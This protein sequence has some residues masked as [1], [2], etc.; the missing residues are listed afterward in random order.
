MSK[1]IGIHSR[2]EMVDFLRKIFDESE[3]PDL[4]DTILSQP[5]GQ[6]VIF[7]CRQ[8]DSNLGHRQQAIRVFHN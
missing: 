2:E 7:V 4:V 8:F 1:V 5:S 3:I 6:L